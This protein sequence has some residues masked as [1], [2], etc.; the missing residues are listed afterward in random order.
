MGHNSEAKNGRLKNKVTG[1][2]PSKTNFKISSQSIY[3][4]TGASPN[5]YRTS[6]L[7]AS[8]YSKTNFYQTRNIILLHDVLLTLDFYYYFLFLFCRLNKTKKC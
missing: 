2:F 1:F 5:V 6:F 7:H 3:I 8:R 4:R